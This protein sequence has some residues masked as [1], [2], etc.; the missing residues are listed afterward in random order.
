MGD[1]DSERTSE[2]VTD[3]ERVPG[4]TPFAS[5]ADPGGAAR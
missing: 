1:P 4:G 2:R 3:K 5:P